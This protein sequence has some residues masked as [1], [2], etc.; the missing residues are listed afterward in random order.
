[1]PPDCRRKEAE[2]PHDLPTVP[3]PYTAKT[4]LNPKSQ[5]GFQVSLILSNIFIVS[6]L[7]CT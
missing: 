2:T 6:A 7:S 4:E 1:M 3:K 5:A